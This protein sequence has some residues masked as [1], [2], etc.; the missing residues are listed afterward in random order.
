M[1]RSM[2]PAAVLRESGGWQDPVVASIDDSGRDCTHPSY[3]REEGKEAQLA[4]SGFG[5]RR[6]TVCPPTAIRSQ[7]QYRKG[8]SIP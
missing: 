1:T 4:R 3:R 7:S 5:G 6:G 2:A 8:V